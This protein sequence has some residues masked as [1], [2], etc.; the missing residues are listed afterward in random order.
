MQDLQ[1]FQSNEKD[2]KKSNEQ[3][4]SSLPF[5]VMLIGYF[6]MKKSYSAMLSKKTLRHED[7]SHT[8]THT[9][10]TK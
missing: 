8:K 4:L 10:S 9:H 6:S 5:R 3:T 7:H 2:L 1:G